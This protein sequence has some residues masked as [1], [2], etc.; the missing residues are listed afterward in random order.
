MKLYSYE[1]GDLPEKWFGTRSEAHKWAKGDV[2]AVYR[3]SIHIHEVEVANDKASVLGLLNGTPVVKRQR[4]WT[5][6]Q[7]GGLKEVE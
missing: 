7:G 2:P 4:S 5:L 6:T 3:P 1:R